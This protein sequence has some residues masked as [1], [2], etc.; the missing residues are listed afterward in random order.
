MDSTLPERSDRRPIVHGVSSLQQSSAVHQLLPHPVCAHSAT[1]SLCANGAFP[2]SKRCPGR[3]VAPLGGPFAGARAPLIPRRPRPAEAQ[4]RH[5][6]ELKR[7]S[8]CCPATR[9]ATP[10]Q[11]PVTQQR[12]ASEG[13]APDWGNIPTPLP[14]WLGPAGDECQAGVNSTRRRST[15]CHKMYSRG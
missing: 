5:T 10:E 9:P 12:R 11:Q 8:G 6:I 14:L 2:A 1:A 13:A 3:N 7:L 4:C 15:R